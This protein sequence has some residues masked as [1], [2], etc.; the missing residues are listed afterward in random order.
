MKDYQ[1]LLEKFPNGFLS[2]F[3][4]K[5]YF[6][7]PNE[8]RDYL[9]KYWLDKQEL[10]QTWSGIKNTI[11]KG[12]F[13]SFPKDIFRDDFKTIILNGG[14]LFYQE[15][16]DQLQSCIT[17]TGDNFFVVIEDYNEHNPPGNLP[18]RRGLIDWPPLR[19]KY[20]INISYDKMLSGEFVSEELI[21][22]S[23]RNYFVF[24][25]SGQWG[26]YANDESV[27]PLHIIGF[28]NRFSELFG[29][30]FIVPKEDK[31]YIDWWL[32]EDKKEINELLKSH[33]ELKY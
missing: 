22:M 4:G 18:P 24:G 30:Q 33:P 31:E 21:M 1:P 8:I 11:F 2:F 9:D 17:K 25:D 3:T 29:T 19:F 13:W 10:D 7:I 20:P 5:R 26:I 6:G 12:N 15:Y 23:H 16:Y 28:K 32:Q 27:R 14:S